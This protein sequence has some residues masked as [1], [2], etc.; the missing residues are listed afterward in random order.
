MGPLPT[1]PGASPYRTKGLT[2]RATTSHTERT[3]KGGM[4]ALCAAL[5]PELGRFAAQPFLAGS[6][7]DFLPV[8]PICERAAEL[9]GI[10]LADWLRAASRAAAEEQANGLYRFLL[11]LVSDESIALWIPRLTERYFDF[12]V[13]KSELVAP[14]HVRLIRTG[15]PAYALEWYRVCGPEYVIAAIEI[16]RAKRGRVRITSRVIASERDASSGLDVVSVQFDC[17]VHE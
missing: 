12:G 13:L 14:G 17:F 7:Y 16:A 1:A 5:P 11:S 3:V 2:Y 10:E 9:A 15:T 4:S 6:W 8:V